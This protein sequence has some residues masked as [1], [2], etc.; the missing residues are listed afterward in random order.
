MCGKIWRMTLEVRKFCN[1]TICFNNLLNVDDIEEAE[2]E[3]MGEFG[4]FIYTSCWTEDTEESIP[5]WNLYTPNNMF[6][7]CL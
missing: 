7:N 4:K 2:T 3:D 6:R 5:L 1:K